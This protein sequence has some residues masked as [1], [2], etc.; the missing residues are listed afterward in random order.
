MAVKL[1]VQ[2]HHTH[3]GSS[4]IR[5]QETIAGIMGMSSWE[6]LIMSRAASRVPGCSAFTGAPLIP[7]EKIQTGNADGS[8]CGIHPGEEP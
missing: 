5:T 7:E 4:I 6:R 3:N 8:P 1:L 2:P